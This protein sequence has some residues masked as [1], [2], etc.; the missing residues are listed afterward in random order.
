MGRAGLAALHVNLL[1]R[2]LPVLEQ[3]HLELSLTY[4]LLYCELYC[5]TH[6]FNKLNKTILHKKN[7]PFK[8][9][10]GLQTSWYFRYLYDPLL[11][12]TLHLQIMLFIFFGQVDGM[13]E[14]SS[15]ATNLCKWIFTVKLAKTFKGKMLLLFCYYIYFSFWWSITML[16]SRDFD[17]CKPNKQKLFHSTSQP[18]GCHIHLPLF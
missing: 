3:T 16:Y 11:L 5:V 6:S 17:E 8:I 2:Q 9:S 1:P 4:I 12:C 7:C 10:I 18:F 15:L 14:I 13:S